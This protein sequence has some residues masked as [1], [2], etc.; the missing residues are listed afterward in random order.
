MTVGNVIRFTVILVLN[1]LALGL[2]CSGQ[3]VA[4]VGVHVVVVGVLLWGTLNP[5]SGLFGEI[6]T[7]SNSDGIWLTFDDGP[8]PVGT[9]MI[10]DLLKEEGVKA[11]F[12]VIG[13]K[14]H[15]HP[16]LIRRIYEEGHE[17]GN[18]TWSHPQASFWCAGPWRTRREIVRCQR[19]IEGILGEVPRVFRAPVGHHNVFVHPVIR[20]NGLKLVGWSSRGFDG[21]SGD[22]TDVL[23]RI[24][25][26]MEPGGIV[27]VHEGTLIVAE[28]TS[29]LIAYA[30]E[31]GWE[32]IV[33]ENR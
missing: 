11:T 26:T 3:V 10:L 25:E 27:L 23:G 17:V 18:H 7:R 15:R 32:F 5:R 29:A 8:D 6:Q 1:V 13:E 33:R 2:V 14:A 28:V 20:E 24:K 30:R 9:P 19:C 21:V 16:E 12:F 31:N 4:G 22:V